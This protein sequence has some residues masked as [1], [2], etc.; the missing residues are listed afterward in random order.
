MSQPS[1]AFVLPFES[2][3]ETAR[4]VAAEL[5]IPVQTAVGDLDKGVEQARLLAGAGAEVI[6][7]RGG[8]ARMIDEAMAMPV[9]E[10]R[11]TSSDVLRSFK[12]IDPGF[13][14]QVGLAGFKNIIYGCA[15]VGELLGLEMVDLPVPSQAEAQRV[16]AGAA[17]G[18]VAHVIGDHI[19]Y[20][21]A[22]E[23]GLG[24]TLIGS[25]QEGI[26]QALFEAQHVLNVSRQE[27]EKSQR[28]GT[29]IDTVSDG[30]LAVDA[31][32][33]VILFNPQAERLF[34][35]KAAEVLGRDVVAAIPGTRMHEVLAT[36]QPQVGELQ[37]VGPTTIAATRRPV[38]V[39]AAIVGAVS[40][41]RDV[42]ELQRY[43]RLV[44]QKLH[45]KG[46]VARHSLAEITGTSPAV[47]RVLREARRYAPTDA[48]VLI[49]G[50]SGT[51]K[52]LLAQGIHLA[53]RRG[54]GPFVAVN[55]AAVPE[56]LLESELF[57]YAEGAFTG[58]RRGGKQGLFELAHGGTIFLDE[59]GEMPLPLQ[60]RLLRVLQEKEVM[61]VG[62]EGVIPVDVRVVAATNRDLEQDV[63][64]GRFRADLFYRLDI[65]R[66]EAPPLRERLAD[67]P[68]LVA[69]L[70][71]GLRQKHGTARTFAPEAVAA[72]ARHR[73]PGNVRELE[74]FLER[75]WLVAEGEPIPV[76]VVLAYLPD[77]AGGAAGGRGEGEAGES[78]KSAPLG[79]STAA[80]PW[81]IQLT[82]QEIEALAI[83]QALAAEGG[84][85]QR[86]AARLGLHR[87]TLYRK[88]QHV[89][90]ICNQ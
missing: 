41:F 20:V 52:E 88:L 21:S 45:Q 33:R 9:V 11:V 74:N 55:C 32:G 87:T 25:G 72:L 86:A 68:E 54:P 51:G 27:R 28:M 30:I 3:A 58:A 85:L 19:S 82:L 40:T 16:I 46:L 6:I 23:L 70:S 29:I 67:L 47:Q 15:E 73:W 4:S 65:L 48:T 43:E 18:G 7:S 44:R 76:E 53:S 50:E 90:A 80:A 71:A 63:A 83:Q 64:G 14:G 61:R 79:A 12:Q 57:G 10:I 66:L 34:G 35:L 22:Q 60:S 13:R 77:G 78:G 24:A 38:R 59:I 36:G 39:G 31:D 75:L 42:T 56:T 17:A 1:I 8:T 69:V 89:D 49:L 2:I 62:A 84:N 81:P 26:A 37:Q 5:G